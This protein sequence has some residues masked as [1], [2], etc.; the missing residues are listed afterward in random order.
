MKPDRC[1]QKSALAEREDVARTIRAHE[2]ELRAWAWHG[3]G[4]SVRW[5]EAKRGQAATWTS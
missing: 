3:F 4:C 5:P 2:A 1:R